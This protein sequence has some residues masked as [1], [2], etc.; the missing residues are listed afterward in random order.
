[1]VLDDFAVVVLFYL[2]EVELGAEYNGV[3]NNEPLSH[4]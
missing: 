1:M 2:S 3:S 4:K